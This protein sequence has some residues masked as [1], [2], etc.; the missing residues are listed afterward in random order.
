M[1]VSKFEATFNFIASHITDFNL[2]SDL[3]DIET[4]N[5]IKRSIGLE[6]KIV[7]CELRED[8]WVG[9]E[10]ISLTIN[11]EEPENDDDSKC[12]ISM[13]IEGGFFADKNMQES[14]FKRML[15]I[16]GSAALYSIARG[17][18]QSVTAQCFPK[19]QINL[20]LINF[21]S[22]PSELSEGKENEKEDT[23]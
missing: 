18:I 21:F 22:F 23:I 14:T 15:D 3:L 1:D 16:N 10:R 5:N 19:G 8:N 12:V 11:I 2:H 20:P 6:K 7:E 9:I 13:T 4:P 17:F